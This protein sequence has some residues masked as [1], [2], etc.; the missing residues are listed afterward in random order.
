MRI[1]RLLFWCAVAYGVLL[2]LIG[3]AFP[4][5]PSPSLSL[6]GV[7]LVVI[8]IIVVRDLANRSAASTATRTIGSA[9]GP[10]EDAVRFLSN[11]KGSP[12]SQ[13]IHTLKTWFGQG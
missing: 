12:L 3:R 2:L 10:K 7:P 8:A 5:G 11:Q 13:A 4:S 1:A 6:A 9:S